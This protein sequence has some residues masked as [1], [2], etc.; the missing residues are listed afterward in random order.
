MVK[1]MDRLKQYILRILLRIVK[2]RIPRGVYCYN[3]K[4]RCP[5]WDMKPELPH[6]ASGYCHYLSAG[7]DDAGG[8]TLL[9]DQCKECDI[10]WGDDDQEDI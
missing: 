2:S 10:N 6:Q 9:W 4:G 5:Y 8:T 1:K 3:E 7:D